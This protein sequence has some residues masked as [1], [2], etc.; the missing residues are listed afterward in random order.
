MVYQ[1]N[2]E[3]TML[4]F[5][6]EQTKTIHNN[7][8]G[9]NL[10]KYIMDGSMSLEQYKT[11]LIQNYHSYKAVEDALVLN[12][13][14][15]REDLHSFI[16]SN[17]SDHLFKD[18]KNLAVN[19]IPENS[20]EITFDS[21]V[22]AIAALYVIQGSMIGGNMI[23]KKLRTCPEL[24]DIETHHFFDFCVKDSMKLWSNFKTTVNNANFP[25]SEYEKA[26]ASAKKA[27]LCFEY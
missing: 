11:Y 16:N 18:L 21:E 12:K 7:V 25:E 17:K 14:I 23:S 24:K 27:F 4:D 19:N 1:L 13:G 15:I 8:E 5:L 10:A 3:K 26:L 9:T 20:K 6:K 22:E 2:S